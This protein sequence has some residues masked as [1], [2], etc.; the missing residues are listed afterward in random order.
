MSL[1]ALTGVG[2]PLPPPPKDLAQWANI[3]LIALA[4]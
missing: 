3:R 4:A 2:F 1:I